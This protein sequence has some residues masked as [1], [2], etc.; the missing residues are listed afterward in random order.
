MKSM[1]RILLAG[2]I[3]AALMFGFIG[4]AVASGA[5]S[6]NL[7]TAQ[8]SAANTDAQIS[9]PQQAEQQKKPAQAKNKVT[10]MGRIE[11][12]A[13]GSWVV[14]G[15]IINTGSLPG[16]G[17]F[18]KG[19]MVTVSGIG[20]PDGTI[21]A[22]GVEISSAGSG[23]VGQQNPSGT[24]YDDKSHKSTHKSSMNDNSNTGGSYDDDDKETCD[25]QDSDDDSEYCSNSNGNMNDDEYFDN[26]SEHDD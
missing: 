22:D 9:A 26:D 23:T 15:K 1:S 5:A 8:T 14:S 4:R 21:S 7:N 16:S 25:S 11:N 13:N 3:L 12:I 6:N 19:D 18:K 24:G 17:T 10:F 2:Y 20:Q